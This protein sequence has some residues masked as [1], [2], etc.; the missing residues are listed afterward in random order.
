MKCM[1]LEQIE[2]VGIRIFLV[3]NISAS[4]LSLFAKYLLSQLEMHDVLSSR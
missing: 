1:N 2:E 3:E 4:L